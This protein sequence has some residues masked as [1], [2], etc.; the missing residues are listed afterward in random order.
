[1]R[2]RVVVL[3]Q[4]A[5]LPI[6]LVKQS[7]LTVRALSAGWSVCGLK[8]LHLTVQFGWAIRVCLKLWT[9]CII[10][11]RI[12]K[13]SEASTLPG[14]ILRALSFLGLMK[15]RRV[16]WLVKCMIPLLTDG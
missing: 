7:L 6:R 13:G 2:F 5:A 11:I 8:Q 12:V 1:M 9:E 4:L 14:Q 16:L 3:L 15:I 10:L